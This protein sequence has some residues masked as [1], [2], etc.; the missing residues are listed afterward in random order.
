MSS[1]IFS[2]RNKK[3]FLFD[4]PASEADCSF[5]LNLYCKIHIFLFLHQN[6]ILYAENEK[7]LYTIFSVKMACADYK[8]R[9]DLKKLSD[10]SLHN[11]VFHCI[12]Y[13][14]KRVHVHQKIEITQKK[15]WKKVFVILGHLL[16]P[17]Q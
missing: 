4:I 5:Y 7:I 1:H 13:F 11:I 6:I 3:I 15:V 17:K 9:C 2:C 16:Y 8:H 12:K 14:V 10:Q